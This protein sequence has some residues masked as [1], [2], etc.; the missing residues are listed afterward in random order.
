MP[1]NRKEGRSSTFKSIIKDWIWI[2]S[3]ARKH[4]GV[5]ALYVLAGALSS[6]VGIV[7]GIAGKHLID[8]VVSPELSGI[9]L[10]VTITVASAVLAVVFKSI[11]SRLSAK[12]NVTMH[13]E[14]QSFVFGNLMES[15]WLSLTGFSSG[16]LVNRFSSDISTV[17]GCAVNWLP[18]VII[19]CVTVTGIL[20][21]MLYYDPIMALIACL[22]APAMALLSRSFISKQHEFNRKMRKV[23]SSMSAFQSEVFR[24]I[25]TVKGFGAES[26]M[27]DKLDALQGDYKETSLKFNS[28]HIKTNIWLTTLATIVQYTALGYCLWRLWRGDILFGTMVL[29]LQQRTMLSSA[30]TAL[31][32]L[33]PTALSGSVAAE[34]VR[35]L[36]NLEKEQHTDSEIIVPELS[37]GIELKGVSVG[38]KEGKTVLEGVDLTVLPGQ[39]VALAGP[40]GEGKTTILR[41]LLGL[42]KAEAGECCLFDEKG[43]KYTLGADTRPFFT[44]VPQGNTLISGTIADN[45]RIAD[46]NVSDEDI[47]NA[48]KTACA[49]GFVSRMPDGINSVIKEGGKGLSEGQAQRIAIAR[50]LVKKTPVMLLDEV[51]SALDPET[52]QQVLSNLSSCGVTC[53]LTTHRPSVLKLCS[54]VY[55]VKE[56]NVELLDK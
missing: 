53:V 52:E 55:R 22:S 50:A 26:D 1:K 51:T 43:A 46:I 9:T 25:D 10:L 11:T 15:D 13:N 17:A 24:N 34:R 42:I 6:A 45:I 5:I 30:F 27:A 33:I 44:Y 14:I 2:L 32:S 3:F 54:S 41:L 47:E 39:T 4:K 35:E 18:N 29:F 49:W 38:Y 20:A 28:F 12:L 16:D 56:G 23:S 37:C 19:Q 40:S 8:K 7:S 48:L 21:V 31:M 36:A